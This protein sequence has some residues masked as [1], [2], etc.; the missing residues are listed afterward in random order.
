M[1]TTNQA[2]HLKSWVPSSFAWTTAFDIF[3]LE[4]P[5]SDPDIVK[6]ISTGEFNFEVFGTKQTSPVY[7]EL[8]GRESLRGQIAQAVWLPA[9]LKPKVRHIKS[10][11]SVV[12]HCHGVF[13]L[14]D[15]KNVC[16]L[17]GRRKPTNTDGWISK[18]VKAKADKLLQDYQTKFKGFETNINLKRQENEAFHA[19]H[20]DLKSYHGYSKAILAAEE[21]NQRPILTAIDLL[22]LFPRATTFNQKS[23]SNPENS[24]RLGISAVNFSG[25]LPSRDGAY[26][27]ILLT[28]N[29]RS[30]KAIVTWV[31]HFGLPSYPEVR[32]SV[33]RKIPSALS[34]PRTTS[35]SHPEFDTIS[36][37][38]DVAVQI[39]GIEPVSSDIQNALGDLQLNQQDIHNRVD[40]IRKDTKAHGF[41][42][43]AW[44]QPYHNWTEETWGIYIDAQKMDDLAL[45]FLEDFKSNSIRASHSLAALLAF[46][47]VYAH[48]MFHAQVEA[49]LS[50]Q[51]LNSQQPRHLRY[52][53][54]VYDTLRE[55]SDWLEEALANWSTWTWFNTEGTQSLISQMTTDM[56]GLKRVV[57]SSLDL[58][59]PGYQNWRLGAN[60]ATWRT[61]STQLATG[62]PKSTPPKIGLPIE[63]ILTG[64]LPYD[65]KAED[66]PLRFVGKGVIADR[67][68]SHPA[69]FNVPTRRELEKALKYFKHILDASG[70]KG[71]HQKWTGPD[72]RAFTLPTRDP[73]STVVFRSF[74]QYIGIDKAT[75]LR[76]VRPNL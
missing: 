7:A 34:K 70:G 39:S 16:L 58:S 52:K 47:M 56:A 63:S 62:K 44:F 57:E 17:V 8:L 10:G 73:V 11:T 20:T 21:L 25:L 23:P 14:P 60:L 3:T 32:W 49:A 35:V 54:R 13:L 71:G 69:T 29:D 37:S 55:T 53:Q 68:Q 59:P 38:N 65:F 51:E 26:E 30:M 50:W 43:I 36:H 4:V 67:L 6:F 5:V 24:A 75:Y 9:K 72:Q 2:T 74:L 28:T 33:Q 1:A 18:A 41:E 22:D 76:Q 48:E 45:S 40:D 19:K 12:A 66:I 15:N 27:G 42:A 46:S 31:P 61:F 64:P